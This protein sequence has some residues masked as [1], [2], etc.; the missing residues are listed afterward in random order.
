MLNARC[1]FPSKTVFPCHLIV[2]AFF[3]GHSY[4]KLAKRNDEFFNHGNENGLRHLFTGIKLSVL[5]CFIVH[6]KSIFSCTVRMRCN[7]RGL[8]P[9]KLPYIGLDTHT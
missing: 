6:D 9:P 7:K 2:L 3:C 8:K 1:D 5:F 4:R